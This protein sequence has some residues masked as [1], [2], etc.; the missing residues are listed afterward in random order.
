MGDEGVVMCPAAVCEMEPEH[1][2]VRQDRTDERRREH[3]SDARTC[4]LS[5][6][7]DH[8]A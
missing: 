4:P 5:E 6:R 2:H 1:V 3:A 8:I 7:A